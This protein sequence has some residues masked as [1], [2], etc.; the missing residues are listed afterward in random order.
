MK[1]N[2]QQVVVQEYTRKTDDIDNGK[3]YMSYVEMWPVLFIIGLVIIILMFVIRRINSTTFKENSIIPKQIWTY[4]NSDELTP[5]V[6]KCINSWK[7]YNPEYTVNI[8]TPSNLRQYIDFDV[9]SINF[10]D[11]PARESDI[12]RLNI[13]SKYGGV[14][15]DASILM[16]RPFDFRTNSKHEF[17]GYYVEHYNTNH[18]YPCIEGWFFAT[19]P[20]G[21]LV[22]KWRDS[23]MS[24]ANF[25][26]VN[27]Y[28]DDLRKKGVDFQ[29]TPPHMLDYLAIHLSAQ[30]AMQKGMTHDE[31][32]NTCYFMSANK[33]P[34]KHF[35][36]H[37]NNEY[38][39]VKSVCGPNQ[40]TIV[41]FIKKHR[42]LLDVLPDD[43]GCVF[44]GHE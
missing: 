27:N 33:G 34:F 32:N 18:K 6:T 12:I 15:C 7:K 42:E 31:I 10:N 22:T 41:K 26:S 43:L 38:N 24:I 1:C 11:S 29:K 4:W 37:I 25:E 2:E 28:L 20:N 16:T 9:K 17:V 44:K 36:D 30:D 23:F 5:V 13:L 3:K 14:W 21:K 40:P 19:V 8:V 39:A 35:F